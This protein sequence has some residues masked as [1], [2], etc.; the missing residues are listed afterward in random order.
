VELYKQQFI[1]F[2]VNAGALQFGDFTLRSGR[3]A[4]FFMNTGHFDTGVKLRRLGH[5]YAQ[6]VVNLIGPHFHCLFGPAYKGISLASATAI[7]LAENY[8]LDVAVTFN[9]K[10]AKDHGEGGNLI[11][12]KLQNGE[13]VVI[14]DDVTTSGT[15]VRES[16]E[17]L[18]VAAKVEVAGVIVSVDRQER[19]LDSDKSAL[20]ALRDELGI[21]VGAIVTLD[22]IVDHLH[23]RVD[24][25]NHIMMDDAV[26]AAIQAYRA[27][28]G[29]K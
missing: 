14:I 12:C 18:R 9:R 15:S 24:E 1:E 23:N 10:E 16:I 8:D 28:Y 5:F 22:D 25:E 27:K 19:S 11:G 21:K 26:F 13:R 3:K 4:P 6:A 20:S 2:M 7:A 29:A 17:I